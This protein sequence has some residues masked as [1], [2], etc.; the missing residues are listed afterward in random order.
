MCLAGNHERRARKQGQAP[1][2]RA[3]NKPAIGTNGRGQRQPCAHLTRTRAEMIYNWGLRKGRGGSE[4][5]ER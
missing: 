1:D 5:E 3:D 2:F 4:G